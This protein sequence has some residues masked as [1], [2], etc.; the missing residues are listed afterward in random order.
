M[1]LF[2]PPQYDHKTFTGPLPRSFIGALTVATA[3]YPLRRLASF[4][5]IET[6]IVKLVLSKYEGGVVWHPPLFGGRR[7]EEGG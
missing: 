2:R 7:T 5:H 4:L 3:S 1:R 6:P